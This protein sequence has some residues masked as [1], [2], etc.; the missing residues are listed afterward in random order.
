M[1]ITLVQA[2]IEEAI[3]E[4]VLKH[5]QLKPGQQ[6]TID[7]KSTRGVDGATAEIDIS[8]PQSAPVNTAA[9]SA[10]TT[11]GANSSAATA[12]KAETARVAIPAE[13][14][15]E[16]VQEEPATEVAPEPS[17]TSP[18]P[19]AEAG[20]TSPATEATPAEPASNST[21]QT[22]SSSESDT[23]EIK[24][25]VPFDADDPIDAPDEPVKPAS[26]SLFANLPK[27]SNS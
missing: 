18:A 4:H 20:N 11:L 7:F 16:P 1:R 10:D 17:Q 9:Q 23:G 15:A 3:Q 22:A 21:E 13:K 6:I 2:E 25:T 8:V 14:A 24:R 12:P 27:P 19:A 5:I 26:R